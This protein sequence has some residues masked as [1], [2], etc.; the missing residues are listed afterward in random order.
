MAEENTAETKVKRDDDND[1]DKVNATNC[2]VKINILSDD[3]LLNPNL[4]K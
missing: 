1:N 4:N 2:N 3:E